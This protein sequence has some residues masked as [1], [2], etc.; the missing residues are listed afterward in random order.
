MKTK[1]L[2]AAVMF[3]AFSVAAFAAATYTVGSVPVTTVVSSGET[4]KTGDILFTTVPTSGLTV[5][6]TF[7]ID[8]GVPITFIGSVTIVTGDTLTAPTIP[9]S[10]ITAVGSQLSFAIT[11]S[12][13]TPSLSYGISVKGVRVN[14]AGEPG[15][16]PLN[17]LISTTGN[18]IV[19]GES[20]PRVINAA[21]PG[22]AS[23]TDLLGSFPP[24]INA[25]TGAGG[26][27]VTTDAKEGFR[28]AFGVTVATDP[29]QT[30][31]QEIKITL[32]QLPP[33]G[34]SVTFPNRDH[35]GMWAL[36]TAGT[37]TSL[38]SSPSVY[39]QIVTDT[40]QTTVEDIKLDVEVDATAPHP[41]T[42]YPTMTVTAVVSLA[43]IDTE[44]PPSP[45][46]PATIPRYQY[47]AVGPATIF[48][49]YHPSTVLM[50]PFA[51]SNVNAGTQGVIG[52]PLYDTALAISNTTIDP[53]ALAMG[54]DSA[55]PQ[56]G[57]FTIYLY[58]D[59]GQG[60]K[61][62]TSVSSSLLPAKKILDTTGSLAAGD[63]YTILLSQVMTAAGLPLTTDFNGYIFIITQFTNAH[64]EYFVSDFSGFTHGA[65][66]QVLSYDRS[67]TPEELAP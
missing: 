57:V 11:P 58:G 8:Y 59:D 49:I 62:A 25:L 44:V 42:V 35:S 1:L 43:P 16:V 36:V 7:T 26:G 17:A 46:N 54:L 65:L 13:T 60:N 47:V 12:A 30:T 33:A 51:Y 32:S 55:V 38:S 63:T 21:A 2:L 19:V 14:V 39:Y 64:G 6:G 53:G 3:F 24:S 45:P 34:I 52:T 27:V 10:S 22:I 4:E 31:S 67:D 41:G 66:M 48:S 40:D 20:Q 5:T 18:A 9:P 28:S 37:I 61:I 29:S 15:A 23:F 50:V 56:S